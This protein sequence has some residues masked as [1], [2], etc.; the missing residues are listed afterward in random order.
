MLRLLSALV[1]LAFVGLG[2]AR[3][4]DWAE[5][6]DDAAGYRVEFPQPPKVQLQPVMTTAGPKRMGIATFEREKDDVYISFMTVYPD[7]PAMWNGDPQVTLDRVRDNAVRAANGKLR[8]EKRLTGANGE[9]ARRFII[10]DMPKGQVAVVLQVMRGDQLYQAIAV[11]SGGQEDSADTQ[12]F[13]SSF[14]LLPR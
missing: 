9:P 4:Q 1:L 8:E 5:Y 11:V 12:R 6:K 13:I 10:A 3:A 2:S 7:R 14:A